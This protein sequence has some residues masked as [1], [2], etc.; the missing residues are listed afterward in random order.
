MTFYVNCSNANTGPLSQ[1]ESWGVSG[2][3]GGGGVGNGATKFDCPWV[4]EDGVTCETENERGNCSMIKPAIVLSYFFSV[5]L[6]S[7]PDLP[8]ASCLEIKASEGDNVVSGN[9]WLDSVKP[10]QSV[11]A[12]C[13]ML[14]G[15]EFSIQQISNFFMAN[16]SCTR[17]FSYIHFFCSFYH[18][19]HQ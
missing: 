1:G 8:A 7:I 16:K 19:H 10:D 2:G 17:D 6:G 14:T 12:P 15:G 5:P 18:H 4:S 11:L 3:R 13:N 9:Y